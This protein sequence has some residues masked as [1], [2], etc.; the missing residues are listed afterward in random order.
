LSLLNALGAALGLGLLQAVSIA[1]PWHGQPLWWLQL[2]SLAGLAGLLA[3]AGS[4]RRAGVLA[5]GFATAWLIGTVWWLFISMHTYGGLAA[6]LAALAVLAL[7][8]ALSLYYGM[9]A[10]AWWRVAH[11]GHPGHPAGLAMAAGT[12]SAAWLLAELARDSFFTGFPWGAGGYAH[13]QGPLSA[14]APWVGV[15][16]IGFTTSGLAAL[17]GLWWAYRQ[18]AGRGPSR[19]DTLRWGLI[20]A[21]FALPSLAGLQWGGRAGEPPAAAA[22]AV[23][24]ALLQGNVGQGEKFEPAKGIP[25]ALAWYARSLMASTASLSIAPE[26]AIPLLPQ[27]LPG[28]YLNRVNAQLLAE[29]RAALVGLPLGSLADG[30][31]N[32]AVGLGPGTASAPTYRY[33]KHHL[34]PFGEFIPTGFRWFTQMMNI[35]LGDFNRGGVAQPS[36]EWAGERWAP[37]ICY[38]DLFGDELAARFVNPATAPT[39]LVNISNIAWFGHTVAID[40]HLH[41]S[42]MRALELGRPMLRATN[43][44]ATAFIDHHGQVVQQLPPHTRAVLTG[45]V[46]GQTHI[47]PY[48]WWA[49]RLGLW[50]LWALGVAGLLGGWLLL[51]RP[52]ASAAHS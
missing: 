41:I 35:P 21:L 16:G 22:G 8:A 31:T 7:C 45:Q 26:T 25:D 43:T 52:R 37:N 48:A 30:Y 28:D 29:R 10:W 39:V 27:Q 13:V 1:A 46:K 34:V 20:A 51:R 32:S 4:A 17:A 44:G 47:T 24:V 12:F 11:A 9:A 38:E 23:S 49:A 5:W 18:A 40:Q 14:L 36:L 6:P 33:D 3:Q 50:P 15:Y 2:G 19:R 42:R